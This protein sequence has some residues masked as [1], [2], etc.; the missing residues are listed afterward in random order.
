MED[1]S[2]DLDAYRGRLLT[3][4]LDAITEAGQLPGSEQSVLDLEFA[5]KTVCEAMALLVAATGRDKSPTARRATADQCRKW[6]LEGS[7]H[8]AQ[9]VAQ[10]Y[11]LP[12][13]IDEIGTRQ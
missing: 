6:M 4:M 7:N 13:K 12:W 2:F 8:I 5:L 3:G 1:P 11:E 9:Q 10:G